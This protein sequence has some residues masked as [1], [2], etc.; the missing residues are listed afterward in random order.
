MESTN[1]YLRNTLS[2][3]K[4]PFQTLE[5]EH[6]RMYAC[7]VTT[8]DESHIGHAMQAIFFDVMRTYFEH[9]GFKVTYVRNFTDVDDKIIDRAK[10]LGVSPL[11]L[12]EDMVEATRR[13]MKALGVRPATYEPR[14][15]ETMPNIIAMIQRLIEHGAAYKTPKGDIYYKVSNKKDYGK[16]SN[17]KPE[18]LRSGTRDLAETDKEDELDFA[19]WKADASSEA[20]WDSPWG[21][22][23]PGWHIECSAM[24]KLYLGE[25]LDIHGGGRDLVFPHHENEIAQSESANKVPFAKV[26]LHS[27][28]LTIDNQKM[29]KSLGNQISIREF[30]K[31]WHPEVL[32]LAFLQNHYGSNVNFSQDVFRN[33][34]KRLFYF[35]ESLRE[36]DHRV[37]EGKENGDALPQE[38]RE[39]Q[40]FVDNVDAAMRDDFNTPVVL[41]E[42]SK[43]VR[44]ANQRLMDPKKGAAFFKRIADT[45]R[46]TAKFLGLFQKSPGE[47]IELHKSKV[48]SDLGLS[49]DELLQQIALRQKA[50][51][52]RDW[53]KSDEIRATLLEKGVVLHDRPEGTLWTISP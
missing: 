8:Y 7:G 23:R 9:K 31:D 40:L 24:A 51:E 17:R 50:R 38:D 18:E 52:R 4:E 20:S 30:L 1:I 29:S 42:F 10:K 14:V 21:R 12:S 47:F 28:L 16:L 33:C 36:L 39:I 53:E 43:F 32:R 15:T 3:K 35:Y 6:I 45:L 48:L 44:W 11:K 37:K 5:A 41:A 26:W 49:E 46:Q 22:G 34:R 2:G 19:L 27:G 25:T 13:D